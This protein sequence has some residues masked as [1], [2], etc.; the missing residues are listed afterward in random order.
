ME[1]RGEGEEGM[2]RVG[3]RLGLWDRKGDGIGWDRVGWNENGIEL[4]GI[5]W[6]EIWG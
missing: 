4:N 5:E 2:E 6:K 1:G 3:V